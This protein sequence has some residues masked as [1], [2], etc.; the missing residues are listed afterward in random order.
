MASEQ[1]QVE[2][3]IYIV[4]A[5]KKLVAVNEC[6]SMWA[7]RVSVLIGRTISFTFEKSSVDILIGHTVFSR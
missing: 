6:I 5:Y 2:G 7:L 1:P 4:F 3:C